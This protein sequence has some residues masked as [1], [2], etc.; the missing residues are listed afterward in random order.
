VQN[1]LIVYGKVLSGVY[2]YFYLRIFPLF[3][4]CLESLPLE[5]MES[6]KEKIKRTLVSRDWAANIRFAQVCDV[7]F[8]DTAPMDDQIL[9][10]FGQVIINLHVAS[11]ELTNCYEQMMFVSG[12]TAEPSTETTGLIEDIVRQQVVEMVSLLPHVTTILK[13]DLWTLASTIY[14]TCQPPRCQ[15]YLYRRP[16]LPD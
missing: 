15:V 3:L 10:Q 14:S 11:Y 16:D 1:Q 4:E 8:V 12:E 2:L 13:T 9:Q 5:I 6:S 7:D